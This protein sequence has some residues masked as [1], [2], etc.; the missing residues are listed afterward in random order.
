M[1]SSLEGFKCDKIYNKQQKIEK[2]IKKYY[3]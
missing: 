2:Q 3:V 1:Y